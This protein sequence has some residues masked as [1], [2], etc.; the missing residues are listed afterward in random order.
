MK[1]PLIL[2][3][4]IGLLQYPAFAKPENGISGGLE[5]GMAREQVFR[6]FGKP[7]LHEQGDLYYTFVKAELIIC[8]ND[9]TSLVESIIVIGTDPRFSV[10]GIKVG[11][12]KKKVIGKYGEPE[13][14]LKYSKG[15]VECF[16]YPSKNVNFA[17]E[18]GSV[19]SF[20]VSNR[21][22]Y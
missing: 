16:F 22:G 12:V 19:T 7:E 9:T 5:L 20:G 14:A 8:F 10:G 3:L 15:K 6:K 13:K 2:A 4:F 18:G 1:Y 11:D 21:S 17:F